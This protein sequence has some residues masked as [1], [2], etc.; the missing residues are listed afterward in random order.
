[1]IQATPDQQKRFAEEMGDAK[2]PQ[3]PPA[4]FGA[5][6]WAA[7]TAVPSMVKLGV[8]GTEPSQVFHYEVR[9]QRTE[10]IGRARNPRGL[11]GASDVYLPP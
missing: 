4:I 5:G 7:V 11:F 6:G 9:Y 2:S 8:T 3:Y 1:M 10:S